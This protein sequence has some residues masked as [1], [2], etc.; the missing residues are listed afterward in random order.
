[1]HKLILLKVMNTHTYIHQYKYLIIKGM[2]YEFTNRYLNSVIEFQNIQN[3]HVIRDSLHKLNNSTKKEDIIQ[4]LF[5]LKKI[6]ICSLRIV[7]IIE[8]EECSVL[9]HCSDGWDRTSQCV[10]L[11]QLLL[12]PYYRTIT[13][14]AILIEKE[15]LSFGHKFAIRSGH[16]KEFDNYKDKE[17]SPIFLQFIDCVWQLIQ[18]FPN[19]FEFNS[20][21]LIIIMDHLYSCLFGTFLF[22]SQM[23]RKNA[24]LQNTTISLWTFIIYCKN[25]FLNPFYSKN[26]QVLY[27]NIKLKLWKEYYMRWN[28]I[29]FQED[30]DDQLDLKNLESVDNNSEEDEISEYSQDSTTHSSPSK[31]LSK[32]SKKREVE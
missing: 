15:F 3:I 4:W 32:K 1:M 29:S 21:M 30:I 5:H 23:E 6:I 7:E 27:P 28:S 25:L 19:S 14:F 17:R 16:D 2:G 18:Q 12:D 20:Y 11:S 8:K 22:N 10:A 9:I 31:Q 13:G 26:N 24:N